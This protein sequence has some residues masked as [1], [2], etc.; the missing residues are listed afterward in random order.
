MPEPTP[1]IEVP[2]IEEVGDTYVSHIDGD[3]QTI[4]EVTRE[5]VVSSTT[6]YIGLNMLRFDYKIGSNGAKTISGITIVAEDREVPEVVS[7][8]RLSEDYSLTDFTIELDI[9]N[10]TQDIV[11]IQSHRSGDDIEVLFTRVATRDE[12]GMPA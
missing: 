9:R 8:I 5:Q 2:F 4:S 10:K 6:I 11:T 12:A 7:G 1:N 3:V